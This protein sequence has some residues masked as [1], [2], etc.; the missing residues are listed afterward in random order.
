M[1]L[2]VK[3]AA[4]VAAA[5]A[6][7]ASLMIAGAGAAVASPA[8][9][10]RHV[11]QL[12]VHRVVFGMKLH[13]KYIPAGSTKPKTEPLTGPDDIT[14]IATTLFAGF[15]NGVG[16][17]GEP[18][19]DGNTDSTIVEFGLSGTVS[20]QWDVKGKVD[21]L[22]ADP[23][24]GFVIA[25]VNED[26]SSSLYTINPGGSAATAIQHYTYNE[27]L[28]HFGGTDAISVD[29]GQILVS[30]SAPGTTGGMPPPQP[31]YPAVYKV[32]LDSS[33]HVA[34]V[35]PLYF[36][37]AT[38]TVANVGSMHGKKVKLGLTDPDSNAV[39]PSFAPRFAGQF[40]LTSQADKEQIFAQLPGASTGPK[41]QVLTLSQSVDD[42]AWSVGAPTDILFATDSTSDTVDTVTGTFAKGAIYAAVTPCDAANAPSTCP[43]PGFPPNY[44]GT[45]NPFTGHVTRVA[46]TGPNLQ[47]KGM[48]FA[49]AP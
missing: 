11:S 28:P 42:T 33:T 45:I 29:N 43:A 15:Q 18:S 26:G 49:A 9:A 2:T 36:D 35:S 48:L 10:A 21:G 22:T 47:P 20:K 31:T 7:P 32:S 5:V 14:N 27:A 30:A 39:V 12:T 40:E 24:A 19:S 1:I 25:T 17:Q 13:H 37:E 38:A 6:I 41:L 16:S 44:L 46:L 3:R 4:T 34:T 23:Q 8:G